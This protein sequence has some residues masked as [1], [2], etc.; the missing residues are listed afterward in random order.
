[1]NK[2]DREIV[3]EAK[4]WL[5]D[6]TNVWGEVSTIVELVEI[7]ERLDDERI[8]QH[9]TIMNYRDEVGFQKG[10]LTKIQKMQALLERWLNMYSKMFVSPEIPVYWD[11]KT[12]LKEAKE[13]KG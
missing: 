2:R 7:I 9:D 4:T 1:M 12:L 13:V 3:K 8:K 6:D 11:T 10:Q 5:A